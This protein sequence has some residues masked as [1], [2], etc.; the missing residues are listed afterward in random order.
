MTFRFVT[1]T[2]DL[3]CVYYDAFDGDASFVAA[4]EPDHSTS[5]TGDQF[6]I[7]SIS[8]ES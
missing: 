1:D 5:L 7:N 2:L 4:M 3:E 6:W 8:V